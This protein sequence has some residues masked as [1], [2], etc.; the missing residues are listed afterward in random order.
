MAKFRTKPVE[1]EA[2]QWTGTNIQEIWDAFGAAGIYGPTETNT[3][4]LIL[5]TADDN[6]VACDIGSWVIPDNKPD[7][8]YPCN[9]DHFQSKYESA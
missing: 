4:Y 5:N 9:N 3:D 7:T 6:Q 2:I 1:I 8:F